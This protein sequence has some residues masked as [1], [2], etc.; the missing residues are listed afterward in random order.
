M[1]AWVRQADIDAGRRSD[2]L[3]SE[4]RAEM[5][6]LREDLR[7]AREERDMAASGGGRNDLCVGL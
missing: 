7:E 6:Q 1:R 5:V 4:Q 2:G 3:T